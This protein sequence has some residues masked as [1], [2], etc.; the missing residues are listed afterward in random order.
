MKKERDADGGREKIEYGGG[1]VLCGRM[2]VAAC[3]LV[4]GLGAQWEGTETL[5]V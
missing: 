3:F 4:A 5:A 1:Y 2:Y